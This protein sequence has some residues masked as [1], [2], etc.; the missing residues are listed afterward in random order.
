[1]KILPLKTAKQ[2]KPPYK[3][4]LADIVPWLRPNT[5][6]CKGRK[7]TCG[8]VVLSKS[9]IATSKA[10]DDERISVH[11]PSGAYTSAHLMTYDDND[12]YFLSFYRLNEHVPFVALP[13]WDGEADEDSMF[14]SLIPS[15][16]ERVVM[17][18]PIDINIS[19][20]VLA[21]EE[22]GTTHVTVDE[23][24]HTF[25]VVDQFGYFVGLGIGTSQEECV[26][27]NFVI[28]TKA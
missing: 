15:D 11:L 6:T 5:V 17:W 20:A 23:F 26:V 10:I 25:P 27:Q 8:G 3:N 1:M 13:N 7:Y 4:D 22:I 2:Y 28:K 24:E 19:K 12:K 16:R 14:F 18:N 21:S 9:V